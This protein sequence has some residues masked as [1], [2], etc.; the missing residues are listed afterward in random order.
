ML[1]S[2]HWEEVDHPVDGARGI[3]RSIAESAPRPADSALVSLASALSG[4]RVDQARRAGSRSK[5]TS[6]HRCLPRGGRLPV[7]NR[8]HSRWC[9]RSAR[10]GTG[11]GG[12]RTSSLGRGAGDGNG[13]PRR[14]QPSGVARMN[15]TELGRIPPSALAIVALIHLAHAPASRRRALAARSLDPIVACTNAGPRTGTGAARSAS[16]AAAR[17]R[18]ATVPEPGDAH[19]DLQQSSAWC[20]LQQTKDPTRRLAVWA[21]GFDPIAQAR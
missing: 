12:R 21:P 10:A 16:L 8:S 19:T 5:P 11:A 6:A 9:L 7:V 18:L 2:G 13:L 4:C 20:E 15:N 1:R 14:D 17:L 3:R